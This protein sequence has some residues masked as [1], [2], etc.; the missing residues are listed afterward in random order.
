MPQKFKNQE[1]VNIIL[2]DQPF[3]TG[4]EGAIYEVILPEN[5]NLVA[6]IYHKDS[7]L[8]KEHKLLFMHQND[9]TLLAEKE[10]QDAIVW[11]EDVLYREGKF[12][13]FTMPKVSNAISL[14]RLTLAQNPSQKFGA[15]WRKF[16]H[17]LPGSH[18]KRLVVAYNL[19]QAINTLHQKGNYVL[20]DMKPENIFVREDASI[21]II[22]LDGLQINDLE[23][24]T[25][26]FPADVFTEEY[27]PPEKYLQSLQTKNGKIKKEWDYFSLAVIIYELLFGIHP[28]Q[29][30]HHSLTTRP[31]LI[32]EGLFVQGSQKEE[33]HKIPPLHF[34][35]E[36]ISPTLQSQFHQ[37]FEEGYQLPENRTSPAIWAETLLGLINLPAIYNTNIQIDLPV[38]KSQPRVFS[39]E[40]EV[41][42]I[43]SQSQTN[44]SKLT[45]SRFVKVGLAI[46]IF[47]NLTKDTFLELFEPVEETTISFPIPEVKEVE[48]W[49][50]NPYLL[51][52][53][54]V[55]FGA[56]YNEKAVL[57]IQGEP[58][59]IIGEDLNVYYYGKSY[60]VFVY[61]KVIDYYNT[62]NLKAYKKK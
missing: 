2:A 58:D 21:A 51:E 35:F 23:A 42:T 55:R 50:L 38:S 30:S 19:A 60:V 15:S 28:Y 36:K 56:G 4:G 27:V 54:N 53:G 9:P 62:G 3:A 16:D 6:K 40:I 47:I 43:P 44:P 12:C 13:G 17:G 59:R 25:H 39:Q 32:K 11:V 46:L 29:A 48:E 20:V 22:D 49:E 26:C 18:Q 1:G 45:W 10:I 31:E 8:E 7:S 34:N 61:G 41:E 24:K 14:K 52:E 37:T 5:S 57:L 33:L